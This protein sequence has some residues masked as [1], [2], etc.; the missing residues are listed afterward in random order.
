MSSALPEE[1]VMP[2]LEILFERVVQAGKEV[3]QR[4]KKSKLNDFFSDCRYKG[5]D[6]VSA[7]ALPFI[8]S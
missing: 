8:Q 5:P 7:A 3:N 2:R 4:R 6:G 1:K